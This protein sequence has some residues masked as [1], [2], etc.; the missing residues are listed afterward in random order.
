MSRP[1]KYRRV[2][3]VPSPLFFGPLNASCGECIVQMTVEEY[4][5][6]RLMDI[7]NLTQEECANH[8][9]TSRASIQRLYDCARKKLADAFIH[10]KVIKVEGGH[11]RICNGENVQ[12]CGDKCCQNNKKIKE[13]K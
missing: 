2:C 6:I 7:E 13:A 1:K 10:G 11:Y 9:N 4:E 5:T 12:C 3:R 8:M